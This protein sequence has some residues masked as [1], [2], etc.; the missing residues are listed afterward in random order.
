VSRLPTNRSSRNGPAS[1]TVSA[2]TGSAGRP[3]AAVRP[4]AAQSARIAPTA[5][6][7]SASDRIASGR[8]GK[9][10][11]AGS[12]YITAYCQISSPKKSWSS[13]SCRAR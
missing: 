11:G 8:A 13:E 10:H 9:A 7:R 5:A 12:G 3:P 4:N 1:Y 6:R 2:E